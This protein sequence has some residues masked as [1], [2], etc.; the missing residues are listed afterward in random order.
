MKWFFRISKVVMVVFILLCLVR[1]AFV[2]INDSGSK[3]PEPYVKEEKRTNFKGKA[4]LKD[5]GN[6]AQPEKTQKSE[7]ENKENNPGDPEEESI[8]PK[9]K[10]TF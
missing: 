3:L 5:S 4:G 10:N 1:I 2:L 8:L 6:K 9:M 7:A